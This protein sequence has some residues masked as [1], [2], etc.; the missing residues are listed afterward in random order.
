MLNK[1][2]SFLELIKYFNFR[3]AI[4]ISLFYLGFKK[5]I[6]LRNKRLFTYPITSLTIEIDQGPILFWKDLEQGKWEIS[7]IKFIND[8]VKPKETILDVGARAREEVNWNDISNSKYGH[9]FPAANAL[10]IGILTHS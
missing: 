10:I 3:T 5:H 1:L 8:L 4:E 7:L 9:P 6:L 2:R